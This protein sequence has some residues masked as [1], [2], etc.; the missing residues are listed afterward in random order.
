LETR[1]TKSIFEVNFEA[2]KIIKETPALK[3][4]I[5]LKDSN[6]C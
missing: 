4:M 6:Y 5:S 3:K 2:I 1:S